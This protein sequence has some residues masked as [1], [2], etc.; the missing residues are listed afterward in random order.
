MKILT[1]VLEDGA[2]E[3]FRLLSPDDLDTWSQGEP[4]SFEKS[5]VWLREQAELSFVRV[6][7]VKTA[8]SR[9]GPIHLGG[10]FQVVGY[11]KLTSDAPLDPI[12]RGYVRRVFYLKSSDVGRHSGS[13]VRSAIDPKSVMPGVSGDAFCG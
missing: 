10:D 5:I 9:R 13:V 4:L 1:R 12:S 7:T 11:S 6:K 3:V 8:R 2:H